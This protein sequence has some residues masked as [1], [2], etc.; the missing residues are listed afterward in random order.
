MLLSSEVGCEGLDYQFCDTLV[1]Y[2]LP[3][4][5]QRIEQRIGRIDRYGQESDVVAIYN[6]VTPGTVDFD[7]YDRCLSRIGVFREALGGSEEIL[8]EVTRELRAVAENLELSEDQ[9]KERLQQIADNQIRILQEQA[10]LEERQAELFGIVIPPQHIEQEV[11]DATSAWL[12]PSA[13]QNLIQRYL[14]SFIGGDEHIIGTQAVKTLRLSMEARSKLLDDHR[15]LGR[16][17]TSPISRDWERW[18]RE[19]DQRLEITFDSESASNN[20]KLVFITPIHPLAQ[21]AAYGLTRHAS[22][23]TTS[24]LSGPISARLY[25][26]G[27]S[28]APGGY[29]FAVYQWKRRGFRDDAQLQPVSTDPSVTTRFFEHVASASD[30]PLD[31]QPVVDLP[32]MTDAAAESIEAAHYALWYQAREDHREQTRQIAA[33]RRQS[34]TASHSARLA[35]LKEQIASADNVRII[36]MRQ[37]QITTAESDFSR[38][39]TDIADAETRADI[40]SEKIAVGELIFHSALARTD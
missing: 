23:S 19:G 38:R 4:N 5:P 18:L 40:I 31:G 34:L 14:T 3:W 20:R 21:Q 26:V 33:F 16:R 36:R 24:G 32:D 9:R 29:A 35:T 28:V 25:A 30:A 22:S 39:L 11:R 13:L 8:G 15:S 7:I 10:R 12:S 17:S 6:I 37:S 2:D 27:D 1:N